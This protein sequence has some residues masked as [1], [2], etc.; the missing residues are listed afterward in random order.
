MIKELFTVE[1]KI[2]IGITFYWGGSYTSI[3]SNGAGQNMYFLYESL[4]QIPFVNDVYFV[5]WGQDKPE[6]VPKALE[7]EAM[8]VSVYNVQEALAKKP[9]VLIEGTQT[10]TPDVEKAFRQVG[11]KIVSYRMGNDFI[12]D[13]EYF[14][15]KADA[16]KGRAFGGTT[17]DQ[18]WITPHLMRTNAPYVNIVTGAP[19][20]QVP[21]LWDSFFFDKSCKDA[22]LTKKSF[23][24]PG[25]AK[26]GYRIATFEPNI[27]VLKNC[28]TSVLI[29]EK[30]YQMEPQVI[31]H[32]YANN[33][34]DQREIKAF[35]D[36]IGYTNIVR[37]GILSVEG[38]F[39]TSGFLAQYVDLVLAHQWECGL[40][41]SYYEA[42]YAGYPLVH[43][44]EFL[45]DAHVGY[46]YPNFDAFAGANAL[47]TAI[48]TYDVH[49]EEQQAYNRLFLQ[50]VSPLYIDNVAR[51]QQLLVQLFANN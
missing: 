3:W 2:N 31:K 7:F 37:K 48:H 23:Y 35:H 19:V 11:S 22:K 9:H 25:R 21:H 51:H 8:G 28:M 12:M 44:S 41:Y 17:Y 26:D 10:V 46:Y 16:S 34:F 15:Q 43:N 24:K 42:L 18:V 50:Q 13:M 40:N 6:E 47:L 4:K 20:F 33:A 38:R 39:I 45:K 36:F 29:V 5:S 14:I 49:Y 1:G 27:S 30:A 32:Y